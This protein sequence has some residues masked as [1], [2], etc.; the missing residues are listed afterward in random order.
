VGSCAVGSGGRFFSP[1]AAER[2][3]VRRPDAR[4]AAE[5]ASREALGFYER[6]IP[7]DRRFDISD[8]KSVYCTEL[9][10]LAY[11]RAGLDLSEGTADFL[12]EVPLYGKV[13][14]PSRLGESVHL[15]KILHNE[16][17]VDK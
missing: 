12:A 2:A 13:L 17:R 5:A 6:R 11:K 8:E 9:V 10:W 16:R 4:K 14:L 1:A 7:F 3:E 15:K